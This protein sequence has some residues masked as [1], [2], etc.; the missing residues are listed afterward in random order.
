MNRVLFTLSSSFNA[1]FH[2]CVILEKLLQSQLRVGFM[3]GGASNNSRW[4]PRPA[5]LLDVLFISDSRWTFTCVVLSIAHVLLPQ[6][7]FSTVLIF[8][9]SP[10]SVYLFLKNCYPHI[11]DWCRPCLHLFLSSS[12][13]FPTLCCIPWL[14]MWIMHCLRGFE[15]GNRMRCL[16]WGC[17]S[18]CS[19]PRTLTLA[20]SGQL[21]WEILKEK[22]SKTSHNTHTHACCYQWSLYSSTMADRSVGGDKKGN[23]MCNDRVLSLSGKRASIACRLVSFI[24]KMPSALENI[25]S[26]C[27]NN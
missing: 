26:Q 24:E 18:V 2:Q 10:P 14:L 22:Y 11:S 20:M 12:S 16:V 27:W 17:F 8:P 19:P 4:F 9:S 1:G 6:L 13:L 23:K 5:S 25:C 15:C 3:F 21:L 7:V